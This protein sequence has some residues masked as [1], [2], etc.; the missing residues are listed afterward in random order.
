MDSMSFQKEQLKESIR[1]V[2]F[3]GGC[4]I[5]LLAAGLTTGQAQAHTGSIDH[6]DEKVDIHYSHSFGFSNQK[7]DPTTNSFNQPVTATFQ[8]KKGST[9]KRLNAVLRLKNHTNETIILQR[10]N[11]VRVSNSNLPSRITLKPGEMKSIRVRGSVNG[12]NGRTALGVAYATPGGDYISA[13]RHISI[14]NA[15]I[16]QINMKDIWNRGTPTVQPTTRAI[17]RISGSIQNFGKYKGSKRKPSNKMR[18]TKQSKKASLFDFKQ[19][20]IS[21]VDRKSVYQTLKNYISSTSNSLAASL[22]G[23]FTQPAY[24]AEG[25]VRGSVVFKSMNTH[26]GSDLFLPYVGLRVKA[27]KESQNCNTNRPITSTSVNGQGNYAIRVNTTE[28]KYRL[29]FVTT[30]NYVHL[31]GVIGQRTPWGWKTNLLNSGRNYTA[32]YVDNFQPGVGDN[33]Y[34]A[35]YYKTRV[36]DIGIDPV[37]S[38]RNKIQL[39]YPSDQCWQDRDEDGRIDRNAG[40]DVPWSCA[41]SGGRISIKDDHAAPGRTVIHEL[42][43]QLDFK[44]GGNSR[45][46]GTGV[47]GNHGT[48]ECTNPNSKKGMI[49]TEG[50]ANFEVARATSNGRSSD[51][52]T[53]TWRPDL[54]GQAIYRGQLENPSACSERVTRILRNGNHFLSENAPAR[55]PGL[56]TMEKGAWAVMWDFYDFLGDRNDTIG[57]VSPAYLTYTYLNNRWDGLQGFLSRVYRDCTSANN[58]NVTNNGAVCRGIFSQNYSSDTTNRGAN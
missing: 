39:V 32:N 1:A 38:G 52:Y 40:V 47:G 14:N 58:R 17:P 13:M 2:A 4:S 51:T 33:W 6:T 48:W 3:K 55:N 26:R 31:T 50:F 53:N 29:C 34:T 28:A 27:I 16:Q 25:V 46:R 49:L 24:A 11:S 42:A 22:G 23:L 56:N 35:M 36:N 8:V 30:N 37:R 7:A 44:F 20:N 45:S 12:S 54:Q 21:S 57:Y 10:V 9:T 41:S 18:S 43:H 19:F 5:L 15:E